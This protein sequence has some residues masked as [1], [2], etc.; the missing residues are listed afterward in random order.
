LRPHGGVD[1][2]EIAWHLR[3]ALGSGCEMKNLERMQRGTRKKVFLVW[4]TLAASPCVLYVWQDEER[5]FAEREDQD[6]PQSDVNAPQL[7]AANT[8]L[9]EQ[10]GVSVPQLYYQG[11]LESG[12]GLA[13][14]EYVD[15]GNFN[16]FVANATPTQRE[17]VL[18]QVGAMA[19]RMHDVRRGYHGVLLDRPP[20]RQE[21][22]CELMLR[23]ALLELEHAAR[24]SAAVWARRA[25]IQARL[26][27]LQGRLQ[28]R[29][30][31]GLIHGELGPEHILVR[32]D[33]D[34]P[35][36]VDVDGARFFDLELEHAF[37][38]FRF[39]DDYERFFGR[40]D[41]DVDRMLFYKLALHVSYVYGSAQLLSKG[42]HDQAVA[43][44]IFD[45]N[46]AQVLGLLS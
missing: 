42:Y 8:R 39:G 45:E 37:I 41:L 14:V 1:L 11:A 3:E 16:E 23:Q 12:H 27:F 24:Y 38:K 5:Y 44:G 15:G 31:Y 25:Q 26:E 40:D 28:P 22:C 33:D 2:A 35:C 20:E 6:D 17:A 13:F 19:R 10:N 18:E 32:Q 43:Q 46:L 4:H 9:L 34:T 7:F 29:S 21:P 36:L 30:D